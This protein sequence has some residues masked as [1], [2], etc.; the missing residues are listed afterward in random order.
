MSSS[1]TN[2]VLAQIELWTGGDKYKNDVYVLPKHLDEKVAALHLDKLGVKLT[3]LSDKQ[4]AYIGVSRRPVQARP[5]PLLNGGEG[6]ETVSL[7]GLGANRTLVLLNGRRAGPAGVR[8]GV[9][10]FD[11]NVIPIDAIQTIDILKTGASSIYGSDAVA[12]VVNLITKKDLRGLEVRGFATVPQNHGGEQYNIS[13]IYGLGIGDRGHAMIGVN[14][15]HQKELERGDRKFLGCTER[16]ITSE[17]TGDR[18]DARDPRTGEFACGDFPTDYIGITR[19][20]LEGPNTLLGPC[21]NA[22]PT[23][24]GGTNGCP[25]GQVRRPINIIQYNRPGRNLDQYLSTAA[26]SGRFFQNTLPSQFDAPGGFFPVGDFTADALG[27]FDQY[28]ERANGDSV[29]P[30]TKRFTIFG[31]AGYELTD[32]VD[33][34]FEGLYN[35]RRTHT[36][37]SRQLFFFQFTGQADTIFTPAYGIGTPYFYCAGPYAGPGG[38][39]CDP[40]ATGDPLNTGFSGGSLITPVVYAPFNSSTDVKY[41]RGVAGVRANMDNILPN[42]F[43]DFHVQHSR[44]DADYTRQIIFRDAIEFGVAEFRT[45]LCAGTVTAIRGV[46][47]I[48][49]NYT[50]PRILAGDFTAEERAFLFGVDKGNTLYKQTSSEITVGGDVFNL[51][52]GPVK[53]ALGAAYRRDSINDLPGE[54]G[55][56]GNLWGSTSS[57]QTKGYETTKEVFG[58]IEVPILENAPFARSLTFSGAARLTNTYAK[59]TGPVCSAPGN[60]E[61]DGAHDS[62]K[63]NWTYKL[64]GNWQV[65]DWIRFRATYGT[66][67]RSPALFEQFLAN[68]SGFVG[69]GID[70]CVNWE[71]SDNAELQANCNAQGIP[72]DYNGAGSSAESFS[73][74][75]IGLL[76]PETSKAWTVSAIFTPQSWLWEGG[77]FSLTVDYININVKDQVTQLGPT[78][79]LA[80]CYL[81]DNFPDDPLC[82]LFVRDT[83]GPNPSYNILTVND[84]YLNI[85]TQHNVGLDFTTRFRQDLGNLGTLSLLGQLTYQLKDTG[86]RRSE[87]GSGDHRRRR[88]LWVAIAAALAILAGRRI[89]RLRAGCC[90][91]CS[92]SATP[93][94]SAPSCAPARPDR[95]RARRADP[96]DRGRALPDVVS[97]PRPQAR[98]GQQR[99]R[100]RGRGARR[101]RRH[102]ARQRADRFAGRATARAPARSARSNRQAFSRTQPAIIGGERRMLRIVDVPLSTGAVAGFAIDI[103]D[104]EDARIELARHIESQRELAD[105]M[106]AGAASSTPTAA[107]LLQPAVRDHG[108][109]RSRM[110][111]RKARVRPRARTHA[112]EP[113]LPEVRDF[114]AWKAERRDWFTSA[115]EV[116]EEDWMLA[117]GDHLRIVAQPLPDGGCADRRGPHRAGPAGLGARHLAAGPRRDLRQSVRG[118]QRVRQRRP[119]VP[120][121]PPLLRGVGARRGMAGEHPRVD[122]LVPAMAASWSTRPPPRRSARWSAQTTSERQSG[123]GRVSMTDGR[124]FE[125]A[126]VPLPDGNAL[127]TMV[128]VTDST[129]DRGGAARARHRARGGRPGQDRLRRQHELRAAHAADLDRRLRRDARRGLCR[130]AAPAAADYV[131]AILES[132]ARCRS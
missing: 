95:R 58:E 122:E 70:P 29:I 46:P 77:K 129:P 132:V 15:N 78:N 62:D 90:C 37:A 124:H 67:F 38:A 93:R 68:E 117:N 34:Y 49:I 3:K 99:V 92:T 39:Q 115:E 76:D 75:G 60:C 7:R 18:S 64:A 57:G 113:R 116:I 66:S 22:Q 32:R 25:L 79:I 82:D 105:R 125:F 35:R 47:C 110:A 44:S 121:E 31:E 50:D 118:D 54:A 36:D 4:A 94:P 104:L 114:P 63:G 48:D 80:G 33:L 98:P 72:G 74:G 81:S 40:Y 6:V 1:F 56:Q 41:L 17:A 119:A 96:P 101:R 109:A 27:L 71:N 13:A 123:P 102:R 97:R 16:F 126:A 24:A 21:V 10:A 52:A 59:R 23:V 11:L 112:R 65:T 9:S 19:T 108:P 20:F 100:R 84:P 14:W 53:L 127:F 88:A 2:Q 28:D 73:Q 107:E 42:G 61:F 91:G 103:Q 51:P 5:L 120:V 83:G 130:Q 111:R 26:G 85:D 128:D 43:L 69:Q 8:G 55:L 30:D 131:G 12:G 87:C 89:R 86:D 106:T 45:D